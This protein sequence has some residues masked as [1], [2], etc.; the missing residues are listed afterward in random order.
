MRHENDP[1]DDSA[2]DHPDDSPKP[3]R[4]TAVLGAAAL[5][6]AALAPSTLQISTAG[7]ATTAGANGGGG[8]R[9]DVH[10]HANPPR[11]RQWLIDHG[12]LP[13][14]G[15]PPWSQWDL[16]S[17]LAMMDET[18]VA[19]SVLSGVVPSEFLGGLTPALIREMTQIGNEAMAEVVQARPKRFGFFAYLPLG[20]IDISLEAMAYALDTLKADG[21]A[22][23]SHAAGLSLGD[24]F[25]DPV[26]AELNRRKAVAVTHPFNLAGCGG[27]P[28]PEFLVDFLTDTTRAAVKMVLQGTLTRFPDVKLVLPHGGGFFP[29]MAGRL[30]LGSYLGAGVDAAT[31]ARSVK[32]FYYDTAMPVSPYATP[33]L[34]AAAGADRILYGSDWPAAT[35]DG[36]RLNARALDADPALSATN[37]RRVNRENAL[38]LLPALARRMGA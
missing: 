9:I 19:A 28:V 1:G 10:S 26:F 20:H 16:D 12:L 38:R 21:V 7:A 4:R 25:F 34:L 6:A 27:A 3:N 13:P 2:P 22:L 35:A 33:S 8:G 5:G 29:Y 14:T 23:S 11:S 31:A 24:P 17:T 30:Q 18:G 37:R 15:G 32:R 36:A